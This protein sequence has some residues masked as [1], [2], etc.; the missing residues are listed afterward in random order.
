[1][2]PFFGA[3]RPR[4]MAQPGEKTAASASA[5]RCGYKATGRLTSIMRGGVGCAASEGDDRNRRGRNDRTGP[6]T[7]R[8][9][10]YTLEVERWSI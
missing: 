8:H 7:V 9:L 1:V 3:Q 6:K 2:T 4:G 10:R 5:G